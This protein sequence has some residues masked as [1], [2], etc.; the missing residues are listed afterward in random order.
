MHKM[1]KLA[2]IIAIAAG[3]FAA[4]YSIH[5]APSEPKQ[6]VSWNWWAYRSYSLF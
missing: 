5:G 6:E 1:S 2:T 3:T 4:T